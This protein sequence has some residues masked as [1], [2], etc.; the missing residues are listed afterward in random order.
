MKRTDRPK[1]DDCI[2]F[3]SESVSQRLSE[4]KVGNLEQ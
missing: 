4:A 2:V 3:G 1:Q